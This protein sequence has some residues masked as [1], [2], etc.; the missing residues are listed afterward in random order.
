MFDA[1]DWSGA[2]LLD[3]RIVMVGGPLDDQT[4]GRV[5]AELMMLDA[6]GDD[7]VAMLVDSPG[8]SLDAGFALMDTIGALGVPVHA[9]CVGRAEGAAVGVFAS[10]CRRWAAPH[11]RFRLC[12]PVTEVSGP[13]SALAAHAAHHQRR[14]ER[15]AAT[16]AA[17]TG[18]PAEHVE[19]DLAAGRW[20]DAGAAVAYGLAHALWEGRRGQDRPDPKIPPGLRP[21]VEE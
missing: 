18:Q 15:F 9:T 12:E 17:A 6:T 13:A 14:L 19:A 8:G 7:A 10:A 21:R 4:V 11:S 16:L 3:R 1:G 2:H 20:L 5:A